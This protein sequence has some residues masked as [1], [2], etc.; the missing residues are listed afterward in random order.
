[1]LV[2][3]AKGSVERLFIQ[4]TTPYILCNK[5]FEAMISTFLE[6]TILQSID[7]Y[8]NCIEIIPQAKSI[9]KS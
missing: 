6:C 8:Y 1:M 3:A 9:T 2:K 5:Y 4:V 7:Y